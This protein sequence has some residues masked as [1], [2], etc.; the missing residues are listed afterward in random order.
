M[1]GGVKMKPHE[2]NISPEITIIQVKEIIKAQ[3]MKGDEQWEEEGFDL[4]PLISVDQIEI[5]KKWLC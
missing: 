5:L 1:E 3:M 2:E 4:C